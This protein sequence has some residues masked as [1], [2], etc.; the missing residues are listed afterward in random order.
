MRPFA[1][2]GALL[3]LTVAACSSSQADSTADV[4]SDQTSWTAPGEGTCEAKGMRK[5]ANEATLVELD[6]DA[7]L[8]RA[9]AENIVAGR[10]YTTVKAIDDVPR[11]GPSA[12]NAILLYARAKGL[13]ACGSAGPELGIVTDIDKT[14]VPAAKPDLSI[15]PYPGVAALY[16]LLEFREGGRAGDL[17]YVTARTPAR[18]AE[19]PAYLKLNGVPSGVIE[20]GTSGMPWI[21]QPEKVRD[22]L[23]ILAR[24]GT[25]RFLLFGD[26]AQRDPEVYKEIRAA[27]PERVIATFIHKVDK[28]VDPARVEGAILHESYAE[29]AAILFGLRVLS[30]DEALSVMLSA[31]KEGLAITRP[32]MDAS[33][34]QHRP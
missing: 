11:V 15:P 33:L 20:T 2:F 18:V 12:L 17:Y 16:T 21:A 27:H 1:T 29:V 26:T 3:T 32:E 34:D 19:I 30:R 7:K 25:Q 14:V 31:Q 13:V 28:T 8:D 23:G 6:V 5:V 22:I 10:P 4:E 9:V 24:T